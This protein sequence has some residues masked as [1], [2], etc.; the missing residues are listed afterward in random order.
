MALIRTRIRTSMVYC[1]P[2]RTYSA[3]CAPAYARPRSRCVVVDAVH[4]GYSSGQYCRHDL[5]ARCIR[6]FFETASLSLIIGS[7]LGENGGCFRFN[8]ALKRCLFEC[9]PKHLVSLSL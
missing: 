6:R 7:R 1:M 4:Q 2:A 5:D 3:S 9:Q 8:C